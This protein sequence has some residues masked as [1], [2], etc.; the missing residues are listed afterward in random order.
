LCDQL[1]EQQKE[2]ETRQGKLVRAAIGRFGEAPTPANLEVLF[3]PAVGINPSELRKTILTLAVQGKLVAQDPEDEPAAELLKRIQKRRAN[4]SDS[5]L[6]RKT[7]PCRQFASEDVHH[8]IPETWAWTMLGEITDIGTGSTPSRTESSF[9]I[10]GEI[11]WVTSGSTSRSPIVEGDELVTAAAV[12]THRLRVYPPG[13]LLVAL[14]GQGKT[15]GQ[16][17]VLQISA[18]INQACAA[19]CPIGDEDSMQSFLNLLLNKQ[20]DEMRSMSAGG[21]QPNL[22]VQKIK[23]VL[24]PLPPLAEQRRIVARV[25]ELMELV[26]QLE[27]QLV[28]SRERGVKLMEAL[29]GE[30]TAR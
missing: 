21:A 1:E 24:V 28:E 5:K 14:Y 30:L 8:D 7:K 6:L 18:T 12:K 22:N 27:G 23:E 17:A 4:L 29:V 3:H 26:E 16:V 25:E 10:G 20:Y 9:W 15:R 2:R 19:V 11:P 13:T